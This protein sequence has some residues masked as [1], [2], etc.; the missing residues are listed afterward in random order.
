VGRTSGNRVLLDQALAGV[1]GRPQAIYEAQHVTT[2]LGLVE[3]GLGVAAVPSMAMPGPDHPLLVSV[4]LFDPVVTR[5]M[6][7][8]RRRGRSLSPAAQQLFDLFGEVKGR[9]RKPPAD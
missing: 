6:G 4:P 2:T 9:R 5:K 1:A 3:A 8:I 7:L